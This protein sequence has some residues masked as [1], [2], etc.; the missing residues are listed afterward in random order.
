MLQSR[1]FLVIFCAISCQ[2]FGQ[3]EFKRGDANGDSTVDL[4]DAVTTLGELFLGEATIL[5]DDAAD[6]NDDGAVNLSDAVYTL[7]FLFIGD[8]DIPAPGPDACGKDLTADPIG[9]VAYPHCPGPGLEPNE[10]PERDP[11][12]G[13]YRP[14]YATADLN[15]PRYLHEA[16]L[17]RSGLAWVMGGSD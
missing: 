15:R 2:A 4:A 9:C 11:Q 6:S 3:L 5:C 10:L 14:Y 7:R 17:A 16:I 8:A 12:T 1:A 13:E